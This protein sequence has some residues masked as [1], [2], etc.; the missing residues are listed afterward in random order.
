VVVPL[1][2]TQRMLPTGPTWSGRK[3][4]DINM[5]VSLCQYRYVRIV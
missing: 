1:T 4:M 5:S 2:K 3:S